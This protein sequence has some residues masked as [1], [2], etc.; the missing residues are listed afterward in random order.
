[1]RQRATCS[2]RLS[3][4]EPTNGSNSDLERLFHSRLSSG[5]RRRTPDTLV[6]PMCE[7][8]A[9]PYRVIG[10]AA[11]QPEKADLPTQS[12]RV[13]GFQDRSAATQVP[14]LLSVVKGIA[15]I[16]QIEVDIGDVRSA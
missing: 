11:G 9:K 14:F 8:L 3:G 7:R 16:D 5:L 2:P 12:S 4:W 15:Q 10:N 1:M 13:R 6:V